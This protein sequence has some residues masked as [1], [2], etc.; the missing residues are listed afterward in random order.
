MLMHGNGMNFYYGASGFLPPH[1]VAAGFACL[2]FNRR[3][4]D[5]LSAR[6]R[7]A[8]G[9]A[10][11]T[12]EQARADNEFARHFLIERGHAAP[13]LIGHSNG[14]MLAAEHAAYHHDTPALVLLSAHC[15]GPEMVRRASAQGLLGGSRLAEISAQAHA[16]VDAGRPDELLLL[17]GW[18]Y[19]TTAAAFVDM[20]VNVPVLLDSAAQITCPTLFLRGDKENAELYPAERFAEV[21]PAKVDV[22]IIDDCDHFYAGHESD[23]GQLLADW[24]ATHGSGSTDD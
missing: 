12:A 13:I 8:E 7:Q 20:E 17:P 4:H 11:Q 9:N 2:A 3:G 23:V 1:L 19:V 10:F 15:G 22:R 16:L 6:T 5:T 18:W 14:G 24:L 21:S